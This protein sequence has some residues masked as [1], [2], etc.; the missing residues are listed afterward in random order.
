MINNKVKLAVTYLDRITRR[1]YFLLL[2]RAVC[3]NFLSWFQR[4]MSNDSLDVTV[5][6]ILPFSESLKLNKSFLY[7]YLLDFTSLKQSVPVNLPG[8]LTYILQ[9]VAT[10]WK[11]ASWKF[12]LFLCSISKPGLFFINALSLTNT[13]YSGMKN[14]FNNKFLLQPSLITLFLD[15]F[16]QQDFAK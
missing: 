2:P 8:C 9:R 10:H 7:L 4:N 11:C 6:F 5:L 1:Q 15:Y 12:I 14:K 3:V 16:L 13:L